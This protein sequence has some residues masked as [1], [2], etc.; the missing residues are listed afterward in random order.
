M[1]LL[2]E[3]YGYRGQEEARRA[4]CLLAY[5]HVRRIKQIYLERIDRS[6]L[7]AKSNYL[8]MGPTGCG[9]TFLV[10]LLFRRILRLPSVIVDV[11]GFSETGYVGRDPIT[12]LTSLI[13]TAGGDVQRASIG[14]ICLDE[15]DKLASGANTARFDGQGTT[16]D[17]SGYGVQ[18][19]LLKLLTPNLLDVPLD[20]NATYT[21]RFVRVDTADIT[22]AACGAFS[23]F[24]GL[25]RELHHEPS[26]GFREPKSLS[27]D[28][29]AYSLQEA[30]INDVQ[31]FLSYGFIPELIARFTRV[32]GLQPL[33][34]ETLRQ[35]LVDN[36]LNRFVNEFRREG[37]IL[38]I[39]DE[40]MDRVVKGA[41]ERR[42][43]ARGLEAQITRLLERAAFESFGREVGEVRL[44]V[45]DGEV[46]VERDVLGEQEEP[47]GEDAPEEGPI[48]QEFG[49][50]N[51]A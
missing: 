45:R 46:T 7:P 50:S 28:E 22:F 17:V 34:E 2:L 19:E 16:K 39:E 4:I 42:T 47:G 18:K 27:D 6:Q 40:V 13:A 11:T 24:K 14:A 29:I 33:K 25:T 37:L 21:S 26:I 10:E 38:K 36:V 48:D 23:G 8:M 1:F 49:G 15:F 51:F 44:R 35:I 32:V 41:L 5:R 43:G 30:E 9:K 31:S 12:I 3:K 20:Y